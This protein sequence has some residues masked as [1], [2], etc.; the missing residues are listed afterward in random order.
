MRRT[1]LSHRSPTRPR[2][3]NLELPPLCITDKYRERNRL[4]EV[5]ELLDE[6]DGKEWKK[7]KR[8]FDVKGDI[9]REKW[10][11]DVHHICSV[12]ARV[13]VWSNLISVCRPVHRF[14]HDHGFEGRTLCMAVKHRKS[15]L[16]CDELALVYGKLIK[17][18]LSTLEFGDTFFDQLRKEI[19]GVSER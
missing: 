6:W 18:W 12:N 19:L 1:P 2:H 4:C 13:H 11:V 16:D 5:S 10:S 14:I 8:A 17:G 9:V 7:I 3:E 15:E